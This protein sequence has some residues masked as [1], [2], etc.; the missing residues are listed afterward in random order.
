[1]ILSYRDARTARFARSDRVKTFESF[2]AKAER[3][4]DRLD[5][6]ASLQDVAN[7]P[8]HRLE[9]L[10]GDRKGQWSVR[11]NDQW[12]VCFYWQDGAA[13][14]SEVEIVDYH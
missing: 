2:R 13:G 5:V 3:V 14:P 12:R 6:A 7:F 9:K 10:K 1:M 4:L 8:G 11:I